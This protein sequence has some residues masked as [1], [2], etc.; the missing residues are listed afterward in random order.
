MG[1]I[2]IAANPYSGKDIR[3]LTTHA[4]TI[5]NHEK[6]NILRR[7]IAGILELGKHEIFLMPD[8]DGLARYAMDATDDR[9]WSKKPVQLLDMQV[10]GRQDDTTRFIEHMAIQ[11]KADVAIVMGGDGTCRAAAKTIGDVPMISISSGTNNVY[12]SML[13]GTAVALAAA[14]IADNLPGKDKWAPRG[15]RIEISME[16]G[17]TDIALI[18][19][20]FSTREYVGARALIYENEI[21]EVVVTQCHPGNIGFSALAGSIQIVTADDDHGLYAQLDWDRKDYIA[22]IAAGML[23]RFGI[24]YSKQLPL[25]EKLYCR[26]G[27]N[28]TLA[29]DGEREILFTAGDAITLSISR[30]GPKKVDVFKVL[31]AAGKSGY[32]HLK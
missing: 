9:L 6:A 11:G 20:V 24:N 13:E 16:N 15:K 27:Y 1:I 22:A 2:A 28:G 25:D 30:K 4:T 10:Y 17:K 5:G 8:H 31:D 12:P 18:D 26:P 23:T 19:A 29:V 7:I 32:F 21:V 14:A 3:R